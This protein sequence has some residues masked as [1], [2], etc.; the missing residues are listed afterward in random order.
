MELKDQLA[1]IERLNQLHQ[2]ILTLD[3]LSES[4]KRLLSEIIARSV[5]R[6][7]KK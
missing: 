6:I 4:D 3:V 1:E 5:R 2:E 7:L